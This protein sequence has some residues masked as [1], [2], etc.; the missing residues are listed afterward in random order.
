MNTY[1]ITHDGKAIKCLACGLT[2]HNG[3]DVREKHC[4]KCRVFHDDIPE[5]A[6]EAFV[7]NGLLYRL[8]RHIRNTGAMP[9]EKWGA[10]GIELLLE[11]HDLN[12]ERYDKEVKS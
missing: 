8:A 9:P 3:N 10:I 4:V 5:E 11:V 12:P 2:S 7:R 6:R 1:Q